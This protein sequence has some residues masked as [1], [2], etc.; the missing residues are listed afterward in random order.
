MRRKISIYN[1]ISLL[2]FILSNVQPMYT[3]K[4]VVCCQHW[5]IQ[6]KNPKEETS[7]SRIGDFCKTDSTYKNA[8]KSLKKTTYRDQES[9]NQRVK[10]VAAACNS[11]Q[12]TVTTAP[13]TAP[14][15]SGGSSRS[16][17]QKRYAIK[18]SFSGQHDSTATKCLFQDNSQG[19]QN[20]PFQGNSFQLLQTFSE[21]HSHLTT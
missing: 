3:D 10:S 4:S 8:L 12:S 18:P 11:S 21:Q 2:H 7:P 20:S 15:I 9:Q 6:K 16:R 1:N 5:P 13:A 19:L 14:V 17:T